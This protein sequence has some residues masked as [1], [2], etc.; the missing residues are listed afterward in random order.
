MKELSKQNATANDP[1]ESGAPRQ[2]YPAGVTQRSPG[3]SGAPDNP[4]LRFTK[5]HN[6][7]GVAQV[8]ATL[9]NPFRVLVALWAC[10]PG[11]SDVVGQRWAVLQNAFSVESFAAPCLRVAQE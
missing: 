6:P 2:E 7:E 5:V 4:G 10:Y 8:V 11:L 1:I 3:L 9:S